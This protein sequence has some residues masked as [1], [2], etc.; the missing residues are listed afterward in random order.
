[1]TGADLISIESRPL[2]RRQNV[3]TQLKSTP[4]HAIVQKID[5]YEISQR[6]PAGA[7]RHI[8]ANNVMPR[9]IKAR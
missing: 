2:T 4:R 8:T 3:T 6:E 7:L 5:G 9:A 1:M